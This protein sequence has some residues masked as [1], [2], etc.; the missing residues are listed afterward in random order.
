[1]LAS[2]IITNYNYE[3]FL[4]RCIRSC[5]NQLIS[6]KYEVIL[7]DDC[8]KDRSIKVANEFKHFPNFK[9]IQNKKNIGVAA[10][11]NIGFLKAK[12]K[13]VV[14][15]DADDYVSKN[16]LFFLTYYLKV[17]P[18][19]IGVA[20]DYILI[21]NNQKNLKREYAMIKPIA[22][23]ILYNRKKLKSYGFYNKNF[24]H[25]EEEELRARIGENYKIGYL[26]IPLYRYRMHIKNKTKSKDYKLIFKKKIEEIHLRNI[27]KKT[28]K[29]K[30]L[31]KKNYCYNS[32]KIWI[33]KI[34]R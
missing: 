27:F 31:K 13:Y 30:K 5:L 33:K 11:A 18:K 1:M 8:S 24:R 20:S 26:G 16:F 7:V 19:K 22:C 6:D 17:N 10:S 3:K 23:A 14:R 25:R 4:G 21:D 28:N 32:C 9:I 29:N 12:G 15:I 34:E 2:I